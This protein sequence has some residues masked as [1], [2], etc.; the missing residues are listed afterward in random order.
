M[1]IAI[2]KPRPNF[3]LEQALIACYATVLA[4]EAAILIFWYA[5]EAVDNSDPL[6]V[7]LGWAALISMVVMLVY[8][9]ARR[10]KAMKRFAP[11]KIWLHFHI[12]CGVQGVLFAFFHCLP[13]L[14]AASPAYWMNPGVLAAIGVATVFCSGLVGRYLYS[15]VPRAMRGEQMSARDV[16][17]ELRAL[18]DEGLPPEVKALASGKLPER[19][20]LSG[21][22][23]HDWKARKALRRLRHLGLPAPTLRLAERWVRLRRRYLAIGLVLPWFELWIVAHRPIAAVMFV[24]SAVHVALSYLFGS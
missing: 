23:S 21:L 11:L 4:S 14:T 19:V 6:S 7:G 8:S 5:T 3:R 18:P 20:G 22:I 1:N 13:T 2:A 15:M 12:F 10:S 16:E 17:A 24:L 9:I